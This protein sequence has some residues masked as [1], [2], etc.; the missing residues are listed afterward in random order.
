MRQIC[1]TL[2]LCTGLLACTKK[3]ETPQSMEKTPERQST[4]VEK[5]SPIKGGPTTLDLS[6]PKACDVYNPKCMDG[7]FCDAGLG[8]CQTKGATGICKTT[9]EVCTAILLPVCGCDGKTYSNQCV[10]HKSGISVMSKGECA[11]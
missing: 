1:F 5:A 2:I 4:S 10:A 9:P 8:A 3:N 6:N 11:N 7:E